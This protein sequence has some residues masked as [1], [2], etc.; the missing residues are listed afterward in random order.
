MYAHKYLQ[1]TQLVEMKQTT[2]IEIIAFVLFDKNSYTY[3]FDQ[4]R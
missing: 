1:V 3:Q 4:V 2:T